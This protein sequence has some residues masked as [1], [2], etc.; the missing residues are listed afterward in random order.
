MPSGESADCTKQ[1][2]HQREHDFMLVSDFLWN[3]EQRRGDKI[4]LVCGNRRQTYSQLASRV[5][6][7]ANALNG[8]G[9]RPKE[10]VAVLSSNSA[11]HVEIV[12]A[13][14]SMGATWVPL[15]TRLSAEEL[16]F[17]IENSSA[18]AV[19]YS[20]DLLSTVEQI[21]RK[22][23]DV[24]CWIG[25]GS[26][27]TIGKN[28][29]GL[30]QSAADTPSKVLTSPNDL[31]TVMYTSGTTGRPKGVMLPHRSFFLGAVYSALA[32]KALETDIKLQAVPQFHAGGQIYLL[33][34]F[35][36]GST[37]VI[38][39]RWEA[40][41]VFSLIERE[42]VTI[43][44]FV[45]SMLMML[46]EEP[47]IRKTDF[48]KLQRIVY[49]AAPIPEDRL[50]RALELT[51][52]GFQQTYGQTEAGVLVSV[53]DEDDHRFGLQHDRALLRSCGRQMLGYELRV[54]DDDGQQCSDGTVGEI[55][56]K[57]ESL[58]TGYWKRPD[59]TEKTLK[60]GWLYTGDLAYRSTTGHFFIVD[61]KT[62]MI[63]SG[64]ENVYPVEVESVISAHPDVLEVAVIGTPDSKWGE[65]V[66]AVV[67]ARSG[68][69][70][71]SDSIIEF[72]RGR[73]GG[74]KIPK[75][76]DFIDRIPRNASGKITKNPIRE[77]YWAGHPRKI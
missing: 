63:I 15:N 16:S 73:L 50:A 27:T 75:S 40:D 7:M 23:G 20:A 59:A 22:V 41:E 57:S 74:F 2:C 1:I 24:R 30:I 76:V 43:A 3:N 69:S 25:I 51:G 12:F 66:K 64:G 31:F 34:Y 39:P 60:A 42:Q 62:D 53:L 45:P 52:A 56:V 71:T 54:V 49:G 29:E 58:M 72:C 46:L 19:V 32:L 10:H 67:V 6:R 4:A 26:E 61:R 17:I 9:I 36:A 47:R 68:T 55:A 5:R 18:V 21:D 35:A 70:P 33:T 77:K 11:E 14:A 13:I 8:L 28:Y 65:A 37:I 38:L 48:S 44:S